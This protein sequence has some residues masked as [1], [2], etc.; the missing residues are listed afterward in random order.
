MPNVSKR[1]L[2]N[3]LLKQSFT[4]WTT[5]NLSDPDNYDKLDWRAEID[6]DLTLDENKRIV[7][8]LHPNLFKE[9][10]DQKTKKL[11]IVGHLIP[12]IKQGKVRCTYRKNQLSGLYYIVTN[13]FSSQKPLLILEVLGGE[14]VDPYLLSDEDAQAAGIPS[15]RELLDLLGKWYGS[16]IPIIY[17]NWFIVKT[18]LE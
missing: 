3:P 4:N 18:V 15:T 9:P 13:R 11:V 16:L 14:K 5:I 7:K 10:T 2:K 17:R 1:T 6:Q 12:R 8:N